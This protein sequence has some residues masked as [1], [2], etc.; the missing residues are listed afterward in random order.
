MQS[1]PPEDHSFSLSADLQKTSTKNGEVAVSSANKKSPRAAGI[2][3]PFNRQTRPTPQIKP[4][5]AQL[6]TA[7]P[8]QSVRRPVTPPP[9]YRPQPLPRVLQTKKT[10]QHAGA[11]P[12]ANVARPKAPTAPSPTRQPATLQTKVV[13]SHPPSQ[14]QA[15][16]MPVA[17]P[18]HPP[19]QT[20]RVLQRSRAGRQVSTL[21]HSPGKVQNH[22]LNP[23]SGDVVQPSW[24]TW[25]GAATGAVVGAVTAPLWVPAAIASAGAMVTGAAG[26]AIVGAGGAALGYGV[27]Q[28]V[29]RPAPRRR[30]T[31]TSSG[32][33][34]AG[35]S[36][37]D[38]SSSS[39]SSSSN[40]VRLT[41]VLSNQQ[42]IDQLS[43]I[44]RRMLTPTR[45]KSIYSWEKY[46]QFKKLETYVDTIQGNLDRNPSYIIKDS[47]SEMLDEA[48]QL[49]SEFD[50]WKVGKVTVE[51]EG[52][53]YKPVIKQDYGRVRLAPRRERPD[54]ER[55]RATLVSWLT[56]WG[57]NVHARGQSYYHQ[58]Y[59]G[60]DVHLSLPMVATDSTTEITEAT[61]RGSWVG[62]QVHIT[63]SDFDNGSKNNPR[64]WYNG[65]RWRK[66]ALPAEE[67]NEL[68]GLASG[69]A[70]AAGFSGAITT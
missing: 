29:N 17:P 3:Q 15:R 60:K 25:I 43:S 16:R 12:K 34:A 23:S 27:E 63:F 56:D 41:P 36:H 46:G 39:S 66:S 35:S 5:V 49:K 7:V 2:P 61:A 64:I 70:T 11:T 42:K 57:W 10:N 33:G 13:G 65:G 51:R 44:V 62:R 52:Y 24:G 4:V 19:Q 37:V 32:G 47:V 9:V 53:V 50:I 21:P 55:E 26:A 28:A 30:P 20:A 14:R 45:H 58:S 31:R 6:K 18:V 22:P 67:E 69:L 38:P 48:T 8:A 54:V 1:R 59:S 40:K 68:L